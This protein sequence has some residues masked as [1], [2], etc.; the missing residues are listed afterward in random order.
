M[1]DPQ[2]S[3]RIATHQV[4][5]LVPDSISSLRSESS[6]TKEVVQ[7]AERVLPPEKTVQKAIDITQLGPN[8]GVRTTTSGARFHRKLAFHRDHLTLPNGIWLANQWKPLRATHQFYS[9]DNRDAYSYQICEPVSDMSLTCY[10]DLAPGRMDLAN[11]S[12]AEL[13]LMVLS[14]DDVSGFRYNRLLMDDVSSATQW[15]ITPELSTIKDWE[16]I[17]QRAWR[18]G[19]GLSINIRTEPNNYRQKNEVLLRLLND[20]CWK[21]YGIK[22]EIISV[23]RMAYCLTRTSD[24]PI[25]NI[26]EGGQQTYYALDRLQFCQTSLSKVVAYFDTRFIPFDG[27]PLVDLTNYTEPVSIN[28]PWDIRDI[29][30]LNNELEQFGLQIITKEVPV[31]CIRLYEPEYMEKA[32]SLERF[33]RKTA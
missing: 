12:I 22:G 25:P 10:A 2:L 3:D 31:P 4:S 17:E 8:G 13:Y 5:S 9:A 15:R 1:S 20:F 18:V 29:M 7:A 27:Y 28:V 14:S 23:E 11:C 32:A 30:E 21:Y 6:S 26:A 24:T 19:R 16:P 33:G